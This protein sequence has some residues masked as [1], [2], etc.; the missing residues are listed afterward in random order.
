MTTGCEGSAVVAL[1]VVLV[2]VELPSNDQVSQ[3]T[4]RPASLKIPM[5]LASSEFQNTGREGNREG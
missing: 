2:L 1:L 4:K 3:G 5:W